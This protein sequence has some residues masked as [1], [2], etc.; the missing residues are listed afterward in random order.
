MKSRDEIV[1][2]LEESRKREQDLLASSTERE[3]M[4]EEQ[5]F[6]IAKSLSGIFQLDLHCSFAD[7]M[8]LC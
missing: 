1:A 6:S 5:L 3:K 4:F 2:A 8:L 7:V